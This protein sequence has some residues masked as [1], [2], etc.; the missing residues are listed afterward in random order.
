MDRETAQRF[1]IRILALAERCEDLSI[2]V[3]LRR[4][5]ADVENEFE[6]ASDDSQG[7]RRQDSK[8]CG[9][10]RAALDEFLTADRRP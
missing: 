2:Q 1:V 8:S 7:K 5:V 6:R 10:K 4:I 3:E 9:F